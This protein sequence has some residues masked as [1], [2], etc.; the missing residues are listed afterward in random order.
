MALSGADGNCARQQAAHALRGGAEQRASRCQA[1]RRRSHPNA[2]HGAVAQDRAGVVAARGDSERRRKAVHA[3]RVGALPE[4]AVSHL[5]EVVR[6]PAPNPP[7]ISTTHVWRPPALTAIAAPPIPRTNTGRT[8]S[9]ELPSPSWPKR[10]AP[11]HSTVP[12]FNSAHV[13]SSPALTATALPTRPRTSVGTERSFVDPSP[14]WPNR[15]CP[16]TRRC[17]FAAGHN[18]AVGR[19]SPPRRSGPGR[20]AQEPS[21]AESPQAEVAE[22]HGAPALDAPRSVTAHVYPTPAATLTAFRA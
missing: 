9:R 22:T 3:Y 11:Q 1:D 15:C 10:F 12:P 8:R 14:S 18:C 17:R 6:A 20:R 21:S 7:P 4:P 2:L 13:C 19:C 5:A 16:S